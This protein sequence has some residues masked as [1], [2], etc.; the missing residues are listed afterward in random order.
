M[1]DQPPDIAKVLT[2]RER[3]FVGEYLI[4]LNATQAAIRSGYT[5]TQPAVKG[6]RLMGRPHVGAA[7]DAA[8]KLREQRTQVTA[9]Q[10][11]RELARIA[12]SDPRRLYDATGKL[13]SITEL[14]DDA[15]SALA[16]VEHEDLWTKQ[17]D[18]RVVSGTLSKVKRWD[19]VRALE[20]LGKHLAMFVDRSEL[21]APG[22][23]PLQP[24]TFNFGFAHGGP[25]EPGTSPEGS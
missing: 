18:V 2:R 7:I 9:D 21:S 4:D 15:A 6:A 20:L 23:K 5:G 22:G 12:F 1:T 3:R 8:M 10:V 25:G 17:G 11:L 19:K 16:G 14:D 13:K 24:P